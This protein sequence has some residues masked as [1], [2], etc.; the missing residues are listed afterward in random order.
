MDTGATDDLALKGLICFNFY[1]GWR[2]ISEFYRRYLP[3][4]VSAQQTYVLELCQP[5]QPIGVGEIASQ[6]EID[7]PAVSAL[8]GR[9]EK[10]RLIRREVLASNRRH[11]CVFLTQEGGE[12][13]QAIRQRMAAAD[14][15]LLRSVTAEE[16]EQ[17]SRLVDKL[18][19]LAAS[20][21]G[22]HSRS[23]G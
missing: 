10:N 17:L 13:R 18:R 23:P 21:A 14:Q 4:G 1:R 3:E 11:T 22:P 7:V 16:V 15:H 8:L 20:D 2:G 6:L 12:L 5:D 9:M 19:A